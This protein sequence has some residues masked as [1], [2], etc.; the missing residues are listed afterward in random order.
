MI[1]EPPE[2]QSPYRHIQPSSTYLLYISIE[3]K[4]LLLFSFIYVTTES[5]AEYACPVIVLEI[6]CVVALID[7]GENNV[8]L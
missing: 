1:M 5:K 3:L 8:A 4:M 2:Y 7:L 6:M